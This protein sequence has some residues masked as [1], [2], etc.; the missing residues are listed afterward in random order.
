MLVC[1]GLMLSFILLGPTIHAIENIAFA[2]T[3]S[4]AVLTN[5]PLAW[6]VILT[7]V[8]LALIFT[9]LAGGIPAYRV[10][11]KD[12]TDTLKGGSL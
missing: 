1:L 5:S 7:A 2:Q 11:R 3:H 4:V 8:L 6:S 9:V 12:I 10:S